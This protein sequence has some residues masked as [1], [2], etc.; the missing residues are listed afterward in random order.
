MRCAHNR[1]LALRR[2]VLLVVVGLV[3]VYVARG[4]WRDAA[5][6]RQDRESRQ[7]AERAIEDARAAAEYTRLPPGWSKET[8]TAHIALPLGEVKAE[9]VYWKNTVGMEFVLIPPGRFLMGTGR[10]ET[11]WGPRH[12]VRITKPF[13]FGA[14]EVTRGQYEHVTGKTA[15]TYYG[16]HPEGSGDNY[17]MAKLAWEDAVAFCERL[18]DL[19]GCRYRLPTEA[20]WEYACRAGTTTRH[21]VGNR[22]PKDLTCIYY[23]TKKGRL[24][25]MVRYRTEP[26]GSF[27]A[28]PFGLYDIVGNVWEWCQDWYD[29]TYYARSPTDDPPGPATGEKHVIRGGSWDAGRVCALSACRFAGPASV[30][31]IGLRVVLPVDAVSPT[32]APARSDGQTTN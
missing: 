11:G 9:I 28:N 26:V 15:Y 16:Y 12:W 6:A 1:G 3:A 21:Y 22:D 10:S 30:T 5:E 4:L 29:E 27:P 14:Y 17:P 32:P 8:R 2:I 25:R 23:K 31:P 19:E 13:F 7:A 20:E 18:S 24:D